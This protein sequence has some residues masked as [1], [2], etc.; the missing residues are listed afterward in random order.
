MNLKWI[1]HT[2]INQLR[3]H[4]NPA[5]HIEWKLFCK[6]DEGLYMLSVILENKNKQGIFS[7]KMHQN[8]FPALH[9]M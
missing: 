5:I 6:G 1:H 7:K 9:Q 4:F 8:C 2:N 3:L